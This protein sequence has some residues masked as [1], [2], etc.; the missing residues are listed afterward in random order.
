M[1]MFTC[2]SV[3]VTLQYVASQLLLTCS[4]LHA[5]PVLTQIHV[6]QVEK[7]QTKKKMQKLWLQGSFVVLYRSTES[8][9]SDQVPERETR[10]IISWR[11]W[12][13]KGR[14]RDEIFFLMTDNRA[15]FCKIRTKKSVSVNPIWLS[16]FLFLTCKGRGKVAFYS[17][18]NIQTHKQKRVF[19]SYFLFSTFL[20]NKRKSQQ[21][22]VIFCSFSVQAPHQSQ[23][24]NPLIIPLSSLFD[25][26]TFSPSHLSLSSHKCYSLLR[27]L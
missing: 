20:G 17:E 6:A 23:V 27:W 14:G 13:K 7:E 1:V 15:P 3:T 12:G 5:K 2:I 10:K 8:H 18:T 26:L 19:L 21:P 4:R 16:R 11:Y 22:A 25:C 24:F 9:V